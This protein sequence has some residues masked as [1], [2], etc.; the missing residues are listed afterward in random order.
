[1]GYLEKIIVTPSHHRVHHAI[2]PEYKDKNLSQI[3]IIW[4]KLFGTFQ[5]ELPK[6][7][8]VYGITRPSETWNPIKINYQHLILMI[9]DAWYTRNWFD[10][11]RIWFMPTGWR[12]DD[13]I[14]D[15]PVNTINNPYNFQRY[16]TDSSISLKMFMVTQIF[17]LGCFIFYL[18]S[19][20][21]DISS[22]GIFLYGIFI[23][24][25]IYTLTDL[26]DH[27]ASALLFETLKTILGLGILLSPR[28]W[29]N[30][31]EFIPWIETV[32]GIYFILVFSITAWLVYIHWK[33]DYRLKF[34][35]DH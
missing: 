15:Y 27:N 4:D 1:M 8:P 26:M 29:F 7:P 28:G 35:A 10:K 30:A 31:K 17:F 25:S 23:G 21:S 32:I 12:P 3:F 6:V 34:S 20:L 18:L 13:V 2:N 19:N 14:D 33:Q 5:T 9:K 11:I 22:P 16:D 24:L